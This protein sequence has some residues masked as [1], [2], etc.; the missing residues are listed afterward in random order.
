MISTMIRAARGRRWLVSA[1]ACFAMSVASRAQ[2]IVIDFGTGPYEFPTFNGATYQEDGFRLSASD[3]LGNGLTDPLAIGIG[4]FD[5]Y[6]PATYPN[7]GSDRAGAVHTGNG[8]DRATIDS[9]GAP[10]DLISLDIETLDDPDSGFWEIVASNGSA[11]TF[12]SA[13]TVAFDSSWTNITSLMIRATSTP[14][15]DDLTGLLL[16]DNISVTPVPEPSS[17]ALAACS[18]LGVLLA[19]R[20]G[21]AGA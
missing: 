3:P 4:H 21:P 11:L 10:F 14:S 6:D 16:F 19:R 12:T 2:A 9:F 17:F 18:A 5:I 15:Q 7:T 1:I 13:G 20:R 8:G